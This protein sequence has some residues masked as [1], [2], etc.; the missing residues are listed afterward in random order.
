M[1]TP[2]AQVNFNPAGGYKIK[3]IT[4]S[5]RICYTLGW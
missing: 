3:M 4:P 5:K 2:V 1:S